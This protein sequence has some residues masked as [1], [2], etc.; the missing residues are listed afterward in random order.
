MSIKVVAVKF[1]GGCDPL[2][3]RVGYLE[4]IKAASAGLIEW[5]G[6]DDPAADS[7]LLIC[8]C[9]VSCPEKDLSGSP[10]PLFWF[11]DDATDPEQV[12]RII[13]RNVK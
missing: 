3:D 13:M 11:R 9:P 5:V 4:K 8:G 10:R 6:T 1:C 2:F 7:V 12:V